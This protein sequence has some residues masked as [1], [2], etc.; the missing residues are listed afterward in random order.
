MATFAA[1]RLTDMNDNTRYVLAVE[2]L[3][4]AQSID[5]RRPLRANDTIEQA[6]AAIRAVVDKWEKDRYFQ[7]DL[8]AVATLIR[9]GAFGRWIDGFLEDSAGG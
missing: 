3:G 1:R 8:E 4:A 7:P 5:L 6:H 2:L 9:A